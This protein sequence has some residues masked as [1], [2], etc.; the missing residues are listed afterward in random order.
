MD[1]KIEHKHAD[2]ETPNIYH[3]KLSAEEQAIPASG[4]VA[5]V[6]GSS[7]KPV[8]KESLRGCLVLL[9]CIMIASQFRMDE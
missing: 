9:G 3:D 6:Q 4:A 1:I 7:S 2:S 8:E 5:T